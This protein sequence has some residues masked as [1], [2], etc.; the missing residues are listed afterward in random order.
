M[1]GHKLYREHNE[2]E[3][4]RWM[5]H[6]TQK[7]RIN[8]SENSNISTR[9]KNSFNQL[10][11]DCWAV[12]NILLFV[13]LICRCV[14]HL[15]PTICQMILQPKED[16]FV[17]YIFKHPAVSVTGWAAGMIPSDTFIWLQRH[18]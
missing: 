3:Q 18:V 2:D 4:N 5:K 11:F 1:T 7:K 14:L 17:L 10:N 13:Q 16:R 15:K 9:K 8:E 12:V 6:K